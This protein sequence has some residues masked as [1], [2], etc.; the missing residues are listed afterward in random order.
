[1][2]EGVKWYHRAAVSTPL[3]P[4][5]AAAARTVGDA[6]GLDPDLFSVGAPPRPDMGDFA[7][8]CFPAAKALKKAK[9]EGKTPAK[10][11]RDASE[12]ALLAALEAELTK[13]MATKPF[14]VFAGKTAYLNVGLRKIISVL[15]LEAGDLL[16][17]GAAPKK[18]A[19]PAVNEKK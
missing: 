11:A 19:P 9:D 2:S 15:K 18:A 13:D 12:K 6:L 8:G 3:N 10:D 5:A 1:M 4:F 17:P 14:S 16:K 7:V